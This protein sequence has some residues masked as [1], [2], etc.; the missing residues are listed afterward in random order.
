MFAICCRGNAGLLRCGFAIVE[1]LDA[2]VLSHYDV[3]VGLLTLKPRRREPVRWVENIAF[4]RGCI[5]C[6][7]IYA[8]S[9]ESIIFC[10]WLCLFV[11]LFVCHAPS[12]RFFFFFVFRWNRAV[13]WPPVLHDPLY[14]TLYLDFWFRPP[15]S[16]TPKIYSPK[17]EQNRL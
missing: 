2:A 1:R 11:C 15:A 5:L 6:L 10:R 4:K 14:K 17:F 3:T 12:N 13:F 16:L 9:Q 8:P 7:L